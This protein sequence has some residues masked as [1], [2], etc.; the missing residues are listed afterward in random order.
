[1]PK[2]SS[3]SQSQQELSSENIQDQL[4]KIKQNKLAAIR[5]AVKTIDQKTKRAN[6][7]FF[8]QDNPF[9]AIPKFSTDIIQ[10]DMILN[11]GIPAGRI[12]E[13]FGNPSGGKTL[14][15]LKCIAA[16]QRQNK[17]AA[18]ID[19]EGTF[20][21]DWCRKIG[22]NVD[23]LVLCMPETAEQCFEVLTELINTEAVDFIV[24]DSI[25][26]LVTEQEFD[27]DIGKQSIGIL[28]RFLSQEL[29]KI[30]S[31]C[32]KNKVTVAFINQIRDNIGMFVSSPVT[33]SGGKNLMCA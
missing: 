11:G 5:R 4:A 21:V 6:T 24:V 14:L 30:N 13:C 12:I 26:A 27:N 17:I 19:V 25:S 2:K 18:F 28:A 8:L 9:D 15:M 32:A 3:L 20:D 7:A 16:A 33:T 1:M 22:V 23:E 31:L 10:L 29:K